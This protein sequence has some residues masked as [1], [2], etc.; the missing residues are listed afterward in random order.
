MEEIHGYFIKTVFKNFLTGY[1]IFIINTE[2]NSHTNLIGDMK[3]EINVMLDYMPRTPLCVVGEYSEEKK[4]FV[5]SEIKED[6]SNKDMLINYL[7]ETFKGIGPVKAK[8]IA[9]EFGDF[10][11][12]IRNSDTAEK[13]LS[14]G[15]SK[16]QVLKFINFHSA[17][18]IKWNIL[19]QIIPYGG[20]YQHME[21]LYDIYGNKA[22]A[23]LTA[24]PYEVARNIGLPFICADRIAKENQKSFNDSE[25]ILGILGE[26]SN[27]MFKSGDTYWTLSR[28]I[29]EMTEFYTEAFEETISPV[30]ASIALNK[31]NPYVFCDAGKV[32]HKYINQLEKI[33]AKHIN[34]LTGNYKEKD[35]NYTLVN[36]IEKFNGIKFGT[37]QKK[38]F[39]LVTVPGIVILTGEPGSGK[40][41]TLNSIITYFEKQNPGCEIKLCASTGRAAQRMFETTGRES[42]TVHQLLE[43]LPYE[44]SQCVSSLTADMIVVDEFSMVDIELFSKLLAAC[45]TGC[46]LLLVGDTNQLESVGPGNVLHDLIKAGVFKRVHLSEVFRQANESGILYN[47]KKMI[48]GDK[49]L[50]QREDFNII[51]V[52]SEDEI[53][54]VIK[55]IISFESTDD[56]FSLQVLSPTYKGNAGVDNLN[57]ELQRFYNTTGKKLTYRKTNYYKN[58]KVTFLKNNYQTGYFNGDIGFSTS[59]YDSSIDVKIGD[60]ELNIAGLDLEDIQLAYCTSIHKSQGSEYPCVVISLPSRAGILLR[61]NLLFTAITRGKSKVYIVYDGCALDI[62]LSNNGSNRNT[63][64]CDKILKNISA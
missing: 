2:K 59:I 30:M 4:L 5:V 32:I 64:L 12:E 60:K 36:E 43:L 61:R 57:I 41:T 18:H 15:M 63:L 37:Q 6:S 50:E 29:K 39:S 52:N 58:D 28:T 31:S 47:A 46:L 9:M 1:S 20:N 16:E 26:I 11:S 48:A 19:E 51:K 3:C 53:N 21:A 38:S 35:V 54:E 25:R 17:N 55:E 33:C 8:K 56:I 13:L 27:R 49:E 42:T 10:F 44:N 45:K 40:T 22:I 14:V 23:Q 62:A 34:R 24:H 7:V